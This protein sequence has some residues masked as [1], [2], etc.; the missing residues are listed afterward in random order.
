LK[1]SPRGRNNAARRVQPK[2]NSNNKGNKMKT[3]LMKIALANLV[4]AAR[5]RWL[6]TQ[7]QWRDRMPRRGGAGR[8]ER[9]ANISEGTHEGT[10]TKSAD[11]PIT[12]RNLLAKIGSGIDRVAICGTLDTPIGVITDEAAAPGDL[13]SVSL[14]G[15]SR[16]TVKMVANGAITQGGLVEPAANGRVQPHFTGVG[17]HH[18]VGRAL[19]AATGA[20]EVIEVDP[21][22]C[23]RVI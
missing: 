10:L 13:V 21:F 20:G 8:T 9:L 19:D 11:A 3:Q 16:G 4:A 5:V 6:Q 18:I 15:S 7:G 12:E 22:Y 14:L 2:Q 1:I 23:L 17:T